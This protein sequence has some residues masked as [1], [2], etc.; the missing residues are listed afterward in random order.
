ML[1]VVAAQRKRPRVVA[2]GL[3]G[4]GVFHS[5]SAPD[6]AGTKKNKKRL[7]NLLFSG[8][9]QRVP[10]DGKL[11]RYIFKT[12]LL[13]EIIPYNKVEKALLKQLHNTG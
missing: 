11:E 8:E 2:P 10:G 3:C 7:L 4:L 1:G 9:K 5:M 6:A 13:G 12:Y